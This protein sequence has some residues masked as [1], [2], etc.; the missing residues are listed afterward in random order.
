MKLPNLSKSTKEEKAA[1]KAEKKAKKQAAEAEKMKVK[2][3]GLGYKLK[4]HKKLLIVLGVILVIAAVLGIR[5]YMRY[6]ARQTMLTQMTQVET[7]QVTQQNLIESISVT[8]TIASADARDVSTTASDV[9]VLE[10]NY[11]V[12][13]YV[14]EGDVIVVLDTT[15]LE[16]KLTEA[17]NSQALSEYNENKSIENAQTNYDEAV[18]DGTDDYQKAQDNLED[19]REALAEAE[20]DLEKAAK[21]LKSREEKLA[22]AQAAQE[23]A[24]NAWQAAGGTTDLDEYDA[25]ESASLAVS[26]AQSSYTEAHQEYLQLKEVD[27]NA[28]DAYESAVEALED[29]S[30][31][32]DRNISSAADSLEQAEMEQKYSNDSSDQTIQ[33]YQDQI[34]D[35][36]VTAPISGVITA[37]NVSVGDTY[38]SAGSTLFSIAN[39]ENFI[40]EA[41]V[42]EY[43]ISSIEEGQTAAVIVEALGED[44]LPATVSFVSPTVSSASYGS[45]TYSIEIALDDANTD[46]RIGMTA[47]VSIILEAAYDVLTVPYDCITT[48]EDGNSWVTIDQNGEEVAVQVETGMEGDYYTEISGDG[49]DETTMV[50]YNTMMVNNEATGSTSSDDSGSL[51]NFDMGGGMTGGGMTGGGGGMPSGGGGG[52]MGGGF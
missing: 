28:V 3:P 23:S 44:E 24:Y 11:E 19:A 30:T 36:T 14:N 35:C 37:M 25:Y 34:A 7:V 45:E 52:G 49:I 22:E 6:Q 10:V 8:G 42:D 18:T 51:L 31:Q 17:Q 27:D 40:V 41:S 13:D 1:L 33:N 15:D 39:N 9:E 5:Q 48:D 4:K 50:Y 20:E 43:D 21:T 29:A 47:K 46:L 2:K 12:G 26:N 38:T 32:N 16:L